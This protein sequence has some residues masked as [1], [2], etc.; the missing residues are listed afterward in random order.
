MNLQTRTVIFIYKKSPET[1][2]CFILKKRL[3]VNNIS[4]YRLKFLGEEIQSTNLKCNFTIFNKNTEFE[5]Q[6]YDFQTWGFQIG[7]KLA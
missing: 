1:S 6:D 3:Y 7:F 2:T 4:N 5:C